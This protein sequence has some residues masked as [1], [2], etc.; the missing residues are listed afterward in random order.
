MRSSRPKNEIIDVSKIKALVEARFKSL[1]RFGTD[2]LGLKDRENISTRLNNQRK[3]TADEIC[4]IADALEVKVED[5]RV[6]S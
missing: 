6:K 1:S 3:I 4:L 2:V 5:L